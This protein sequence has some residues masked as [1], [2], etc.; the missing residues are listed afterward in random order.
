VIS[1]ISYENVKNKWFPEI[2]QHCPGVPIILAGCKGDLRNDPETLE[3]LRAQNRRP[4][5]TSEIDALIK[6]TGAVKYV[7]SSALTQDG[8]ADVFEGAIRAVLHGKPR[9]PNKRKCTIL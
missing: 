6:Y 2:N 7:E 8:L 9:K 5:S 3:S 1:Q 4:V